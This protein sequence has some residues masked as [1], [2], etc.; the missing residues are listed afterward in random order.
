MINKRFAGIFLSLISMLISCVLMATAG[1]LTFKQSTQ[2]RE[3]GRT[4][5]ASSRNQRLMPPES[6]KCADNDVT[7]F[8]GRVLAYRRAA[9]NISL[10]MRT[11]EETT[12]HFT[13]RYAKADGPAKLFLLRAEPF[14]PEDW[15]VIESRP[16]KLRPGMRAT[17]WVCNDGA[18]PTVVDWKP[19]PD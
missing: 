14:K 15:T 9:T 2:T 6:L 1:N 8:T 18:T 11:D 4:T 5:T 19:R 7:S 16:G 12:E 13:L 10:R 3:A 17:V